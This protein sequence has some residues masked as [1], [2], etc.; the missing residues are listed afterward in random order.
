M[1]ESPMAVSFCG[2]CGQPLASGHSFCSRCGARV[3]GPWTPTPGAYSP[4]PPA[5]PRSSPIV[6]VVLVV[7]LVLTAAAILGGFEFGALAGRGFCHCPGDTPIGTAFRPGV[8]TAGQCPLDATFLSTGCQG[9]ADFYYRVSI[10]DSTISFGSAWFFVQTPSGSIDV[11]PS[12]LG[13]TI[14]TE[15]GAVAAQYAAAGGSMGMTSD[16]TFGSG[17]VDGTPVLTSDYIVIDMGTQNPSGL[18]LEFVAQAMGSYTGTTN[19]LPLP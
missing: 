7:V 2:R 11:A 5:P 14:L 15:N 8:P 10:I 3:S 12:G 6:A 13:F 19:P 16:W 18:G 17:V 4:G 9:P 1:E